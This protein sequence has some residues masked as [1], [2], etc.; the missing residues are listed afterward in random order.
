MSLDAE[1]RALHASHVKAKI[2]SP[3][4]PIPTQAAGPSSAFSVPFPNEHHCVRLPRLTFPLARLA[5]TQ[6]LSARSLVF[7]WLQRG[8]VNPTLLKPFPVSSLRTDSS[9]RNKEEARFR[10]LQ[11]LHFRRVMNCCAEMKPWRC[12]QKK[13]PSVVAGC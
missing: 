2:P 1:F 5:F 12:L 4:T 11:A 9:A 7:G 10:F 13:V 3:A 6:L 8:E